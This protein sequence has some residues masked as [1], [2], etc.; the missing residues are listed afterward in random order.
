M[1]KE[2]EIFLTGLRTN[3][4]YHL[5]NYI[6]ALLP[7]IHLIQAKGDNERYQINLFAPDLHSFIT[8]IDFSRL[9]HQTLDNL[10]LFVA[11]GIPL[12][13][14]NINL[15]RQSH[16]PAHSELTWIMS[17]FASFG[18]LSRMIE[19]KEKSAQMKQEAQI[20]AGLFMYPILMAVDILLY[21]AKWI[22]VGDDQRQHLEFCRRL[23]KSF[24][25][26]FQ[27][28]IFTI[29]AAFEKQQVWLG[30]EQAP[31][32]RSLRHPDKKMSKSIADEKGTIMLLDKAEVVAEKIMGATTDNLACINYDW[33]NQAGITN[34]LTIL[35]S[36]TKQ[37][38]AETNAI[39][40][41]SHD[42]RA[43]KIAVIAAVQ[44]TLKDLQDSLAMVSQEALMTHLE[45]REQALNKIANLKLFRI[46]RLIGLR[47]PA[48]K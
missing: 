40:R 5:G 14:A 41:G 8:P 28:D 3:S 9:Y 36:L 32:I 20:K 11:A 24:N 13:Q 35:A 22:P 37:N 43:L 23:A 25:T 29:P 47:K 12:D 31:R 7:L 4:Q 33:Q 46:Q 44:A 45:E 19:F 15:Y 38:Q 18:D 17:N 21:D 34:L 48:D 27:E 39:W 42:Y 10:K 2:R 30:R 1:E 6:G 16:I 26:E